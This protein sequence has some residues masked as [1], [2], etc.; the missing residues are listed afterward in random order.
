MKRTKLVFT[1]VLALGLLFCVNDATAQ[2]TVKKAKAQKSIQTQNNQQTKSANVI[3]KTYTY[4]GKT[5]MLNPPLIPNA[6]MPSTV[7]KPALK[8]SPR[9]D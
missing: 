6:L 4:K 3:G 7:E 9:Q 1:S 8:N 2:Q 5:M